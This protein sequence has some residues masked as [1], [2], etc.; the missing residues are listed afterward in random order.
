MQYFKPNGEHAFAGDCMPFWHDGIFHLY[1]LADEDHH[2]ALGGLGG[3]QWAHASSPDLVHWTHHELAIAIT[4]PWEGS[5]CTGSVLHDNGTYYGFY[6]TRL[7]DRTQHLSLA[8]SDDGVRFSKTMPNPLA[9]PPSG[10]NAYHYRDP[11]VFRDTGSGL[12]HLLVT[13]CL[14]DY[15]VYGRGGC[16]AHLTSA[17]L[18]TW[19][20]QAPF[21]LPGLPDV[22]ECP[23][24]FAWNGWYYLVFSVGGVARYR[25]S[26]E[27]FG[28]WHRPASDTFD[29]SA[30]CVMKTA[31]FGD[32]RRIGA[33]WVGT[34]LGGSDQGPLQFGG[35][36]VFRE[37][38]QN[39]DGSLGT[40][41]P[42]EMIPATGDTLSLR[43][44]PVTDR[45]VTDCSRVQ[46]MAE[47]G[48]EVAMLE[49]I[50][51]DIR[52]TMV[53][54]PAPGS[55]VFGLSL[56]AAGDMKSGYDLRFLP[57]EGRVELFDRVL[58]GLKELRG[59]FTLEIMLTDDLI[60]V[61]IDQRHC[62]VNRCPELHG[63]RL[64]FF[65]LNAV[66]S[67]D[68]LEVRPLLTPFSERGQ[69]TPRG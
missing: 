4:E 33:A 29:G 32:E 54:R 42:A 35:H 22:P 9:S 60:D 5:I 68:A 27:P 67:F 62:L 13:A 6:A 51:G 19:D 18:S 64:F 7:R 39:A 43:P 15:P 52:M 59:T 30:A 41:F 65:A 1:Y 69:D 26:R 37:I 16:L 25:M 3:H 40:Q 38:V 20:V 12:Y 10:Y 17:D 66:V 21:L 14:D 36:I 45:T 11:F 61:C 58:T 46:L 24:Y 63:E 49:E 34:R 56:R 23:D 57:L 31:A 48:L 2:A 53:V 55:A 44:V 8:T 47:E 50:P 28:P